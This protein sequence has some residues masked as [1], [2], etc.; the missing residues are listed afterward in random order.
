MVKQPS[1]QESVGYWVTR[2]A[3][4]MEQDFESR[5]QA[6]GITRGA[7]AALSAIHFDARCTPAELVGFLGIDGAAITRHLDRIEKNGLIERRPGA[8]DRR[9][10]DIT[11]T[12]KGADTVKQG[13]A[14]SRATNKK[15]IQDLSKEEVDALRSTIQTI[16]KVTGGNIADV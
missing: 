7:Y 12:P 2:L 3:R 16:L 8:S 11:L 6:L 10:V 15:F 9:S 14:A 4:S 5:L 1:V 13:H